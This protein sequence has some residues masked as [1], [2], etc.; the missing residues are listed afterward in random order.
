MITDSAKLNIPDERKESLARQESPKPTILIVEDEAGPREALKMILR[1]FFN[2]YAVDNAEVALHMLKERPIDLVTLDLKLPA[3]QGTDLLR[4][5]KREHEFV[6]VVIITGYGSLQSALEG[7][8]CGAAA[9]LLKPFNVTELIDV[10]NKALEKKNHLDGLRDTL[11]TF[12]SLWATELDSTTACKNLGRLLE[13]KDQELVRHSRRVAFYASLLAEHLDLTSED[14]VALQIGAFLH[15]IG[16]VGIDDRILM[17]S[18]KLSDRESELV[19]CHP[20]IG[21]RM[22]GT[23][24]LPEGVGRIIRHHH[25]QYDGSGYPDGLQGEGIPYLARIV[26]LANVF[27]KLITNPPTQGALTIEEARQYVRQQAG[28][29]FDPRLAELFAQVV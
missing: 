15:D 27:D 2:L 3:L 23:L 12:G 22:V 25:E 5:I 24:P 28:I 4:E 17:N 10:I 26:C 29:L 7:I 8:R 6:E 13:A 20:D 21:A 18:S 11:R 14:R 16:K 9:Y 19:K 1:P